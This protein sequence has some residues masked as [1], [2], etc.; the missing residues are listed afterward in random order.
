MKKLIAILLLSNYLAFGQLQITIDSLS[1]NTSCFNETITVYVHGNNPLS[2]SNSNTTLNLNS[3]T[4]YGYLG[5]ISSCTY[6]QLCDSGF[7]K[8]YTYW[9]H[10]TADSI[11]TIGFNTISQKQFKV[12]NCQAGIENYNS[13]EDLISTEY[14]NLLGQPIKQ[15]EGITVE[16]KTYRNG[17][18]EVR[19]IVN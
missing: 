8:F 16:V 19:K 9:Y 18:K 10:F 12:N 5:T 14:Y 3:E 15:P 11:A 6:K 17:Q 13:K 4:N 2:T 1:K 7:V